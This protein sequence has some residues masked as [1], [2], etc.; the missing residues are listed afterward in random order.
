MPIQTV[1]N[2]DARRCLDQ[3]ETFQH[4]LLEEPPRAG[5]PASGPPDTVALEQRAAEACR[6]CPLLAGC[7]YEAVV[8]HDVA[9]MSPA[10]RPRSGSRSVRCLDVDVDAGEPRYPRRHRRRQSSGRPRR[11][12]T[13]AGRQSRREPGAAGAAARL[14][15]VHR[16]APPAARAGRRRR[17]S[18]SR[19]GPAEH[20]RGA[21]AASRRCSTLSGTSVRPPES[22]SPSSSERGYL[23]HGRPPRKPSS[24]GWALPSCFPSPRPPPR[25]REKWALTTSLL[26]VSLSFAP[27]FGSGT[28]EAELSRT[29]GAARQRDRRR[30]TGRWSH[31][32]PPGPRPAR[33]RS[34]LRGRPS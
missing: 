8:R 3:A 4:P 23:R 7:L 18:R 21:P 10:Q 20:G 11:G 30:R 15:A 29:S 22:R 32:R 12:R 6:T 33:P 34:L 5:A 27:S 25:P 28:T 24:P 14:L 31:R 2:R 1:P 26:G 13:P 16:E 19:N 17:R 9:A